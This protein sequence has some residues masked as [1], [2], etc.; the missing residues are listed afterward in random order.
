M[1][2]SILG[3]G[4]GRQEG[5]RKW[6][7]RGGKHFLL[8]GGGEGT[9]KFQKALKMHFLK[10]VLE[11]CSKYVHFCILK[12]HFYYF[13]FQ[14]GK[15]FLVTKGWSNFFLGQ[16]GSIKC[17]AGGGIRTLPFR[18]G[19][20]VPFPPM[21]T[22]VSTAKLILTS[23]ARSA[24]FQSAFAHSAKSQKYGALTEL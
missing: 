23:A 3:H 20:T 13:Y 19:V 12:A 14:Y 18:K 2:P 22:Y 1:V 11:I 7:G 17:P 4:G 9:V 10:K 8:Q 24:H 5:G 21:P 6:A 15:N 16:G